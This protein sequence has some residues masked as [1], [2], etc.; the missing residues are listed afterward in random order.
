MKHRDEFAKALPPEVRSELFIRVALTAINKIPKLLECDQSSIMQGLL[1]VAQLGLVLDGQEAVLIPYNDSRRGMVAQLQIGYSGLLRLAYNSPKVKAIRGNI[2]HERDKFEYSDGFEPKLVHVPSDDDDPGEIVKAYA[3]ADLA[4]GGRTWVVIS[5]RDWEKAERSSKTA[6]QS[7]S[8]WKLWREAMVMKTAFRQLSKRIPKSRQLMEALA[9]D[10]EDS[11]I[12]VASQVMNQ[13]PTIADVQPEPPAKQEPEV[14]PE[15]VAAKPKKA[16]A[17]PAPAPKPADP[18]IVPAPVDGGTPAPD[19]FEESEDH[20][21][22]RQLMEESGISEA[23]FL[24][25]ARGEALID[26]AVRDL[27]GIPH[28]RVRTFVMS[29]DTIMEKMGRK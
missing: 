14:K 3:I 9:K 6:D 1:D 26:E 12:D 18:R 27:R 16:K 7:S 23:N 15:P 19:L 17:E 2:V 13:T 22:L 11:V 21:T 5:K 24:E 20:V 25:Y 28:R 4:D 29:W 8:P 10:A